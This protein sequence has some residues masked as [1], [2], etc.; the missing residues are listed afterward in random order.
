MA[1]GHVNRINR[2]NT[3]LLRPDLRREESPCQ[4]GAVHTW[5]KTDEDDQALECPYAGEPDVDRSLSS[6]Q[7][8]THTRTATTPALGTGTSRRR[9]GRRKQIAPLIGRAIARWAITHT[10]RANTSE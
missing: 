2:P 1:S 3:W 5:H 10:L 7:F 8:L 9:L 6:S 4:H